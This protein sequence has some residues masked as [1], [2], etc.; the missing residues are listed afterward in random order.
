M[1]AFKKISDRLLP[2]L[3]LLSLFCLILLIARLFITDTFRFWFIPENLALA[4]LAL[5]FGWLLIWG[6]E[7]WRWLTWQNLSLSILWLIFLPNSW[8][9]LTDFLHVFSTGEISQLY[10]IIMVFSMVVVGFTLGFVSL[11]LVHLEL[12]KRWP[13]RWA[14]AGVA[15]VLLLSS[16]GI[17]IGRDLRWNTWD[18]LAN[19]GGL[20]VNVSDRLVAPLEHSRA[21]NVTILFFTMLSVFYLAFW[22]AAGPHKYKKRRI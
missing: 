15:V 10:D 16:F 9:V 21:L 6:L 13:V 2:A 12:L 1:E 14:H 17:H 3:G 5:F 8:Y 7:R 19:P 11:Y 18:V 20:I 22:L 4:W